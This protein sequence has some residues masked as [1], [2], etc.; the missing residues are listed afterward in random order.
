MKQQRLQVGIPASAHASLSE[1]RSN[2]GH[3]W[4]EG[5]CQNS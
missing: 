2:A 1:V 5:Q 3:G 4:A